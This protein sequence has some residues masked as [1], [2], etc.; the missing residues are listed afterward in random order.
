MMNDD[1]NGISFACV[2]FFVSVKLVSTNVGEYVFVCPNG[3]GKDS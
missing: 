3:T 1:G 2:I